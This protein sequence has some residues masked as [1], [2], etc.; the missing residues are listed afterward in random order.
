MQGP[1]RSKDH[2]ATLSARRVLDVNTVARKRGTEIRRQ[3]Q[4]CFRT[5]V[6]HVRE[7]QLTSIRLAFWRLLH[8][9]PRR[10]VSQIIN[11]ESRRSGHG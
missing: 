1:E 8:A 11:A 3:P 5:I 10:N 7:G 9:A 6:H 4:T 2:E